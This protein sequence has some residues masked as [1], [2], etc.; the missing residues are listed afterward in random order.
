MLRREGVHDA[1]WR[2]IGHH[3]PWSVCCGATSGYGTLTAQS[4]W[5]SACS[6]ILCSLEYQFVSMVPTAFREVLGEEELSYGVILWVR[7]GF[8]VE[9]LYFLRESCHT[10]TCSHF[11]L[12]PDAAWEDYSLQ[13]P[14]TQA[15]LAFHSKNTLFWQ[16]RRPHCQHASGWRDLSGVVHWG[17]HVV[18]PCVL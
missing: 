16:A 14:S 18:L 9:L 4:V 7:W 10:C 3:C 1:A 15:D 17:L 11:P 13:I 2:F 8:Q 12:F 6:K 5:V